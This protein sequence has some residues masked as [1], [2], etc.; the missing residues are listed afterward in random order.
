M[1]SGLLEWKIGIITPFD[2]SDDNRVRRVT[3][4]YK[5][6]RKD[7]AFDH[8]TNIERGVH[9]LIGLVPVED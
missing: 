2:P 1:H 9:K 4:S 5:N 7:D 6:C 8:C 3:V